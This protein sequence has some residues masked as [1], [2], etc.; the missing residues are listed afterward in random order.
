MR[1]YMRFDTGRNDDY[2][3]ENDADAKDAEVSGE[4]I[5]RKADSGGD[6]DS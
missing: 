3:S 5:K 6:K 1:M 2:F 4:K